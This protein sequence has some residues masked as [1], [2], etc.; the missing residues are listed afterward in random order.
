MLINDLYKKSLLTNVF[1]TYVRSTEYLDIVLTSVRT[2]YKVGLLEVVKVDTFADLLKYKDL[3]NSVSLFSDKYVFYIENALT[4][5]SMEVLD[6]LASSKSYSLVVGVKNYGVFDKLRRN[7]QLNNRVNVDYL[8]SSRLH[9]D[10]F[11][12]LYR[13]T[14]NLEGVTPLPDDIYKK[15]KLGYLQEVTAVFKLLDEIKKGSK[16]LTTNDLVACAGLGNLSVDAIVYSLLTTSAKTPKGVKVYK[17]KVLPKVLEILQRMSVGTFRNQFEESLR[18]AY[19]IKVLTLKGYLLQGLESK[20]KDFKGYEDNTRLSFYERRREKLQEVPISRIVNLMT[21]LDRENAWY[22]EYQVVGY[23]EKCLT[24]RL[25]NNIN[26]A[27][28]V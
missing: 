11:D 21:L 5:P 16:I 3:F 7:N 8:Y 9:K 15:V 6:L 22:Y 12:L 28:V 24:S 26:K 23:F 13:F 10:E 19:D 27:E 20:A 14:L 4:L 25:L 17:K 18:A 1:I 2:R